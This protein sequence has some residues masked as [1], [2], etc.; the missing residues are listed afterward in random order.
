MGAW[1]LFRAV[2]SAGY[3]KSPNAGLSRSKLG[4][5]F[6]LP[7]RSRPF[8]SANVNSFVPFG[9]KFKANI[10]LAYTLTGIFEN[11]IRVQFPLPQINATYGG[12]G[13]PYCSDS[14]SVGGKPTT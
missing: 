13:L 8:F 4:G 9:G 6:A 7:F 12:L 1:T 14:T 11:G 3:F 5:S 10:L 2:A